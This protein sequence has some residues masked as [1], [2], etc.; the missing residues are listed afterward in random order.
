MHMD[1]DA[2]RGLA[3][4]SVVSLWECSFDCFYFL[5]EIKGNVNILRST[6]DCPTKLN[7]YWILATQI[8]SLTTLKCEFYYIKKK[9]KVYAIQQN[10]H[11]D[12][13]LR[14]WGIMI[15]CEYKGVSN[16]S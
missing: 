2:R 14:N 8:L 10:S 5:S 4:I 15:L 16:T 12:Y 9:K 3:A 13:Y 1:S 11:W 7:L 6:P